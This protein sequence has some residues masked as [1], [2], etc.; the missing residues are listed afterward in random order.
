MR[1]LSALL[2]LVLVAAL[3]VVALSAQF[4]TYYPPSALFAASAI[5]SSS[6]DGVNHALFGVNQG[7][8][9]LY[10]IFLAPN[11]TPAFGAT[12][13]FPWVYGKLVGAQFI[14]AN[15]VRATWVISLSGGG[16]NAVFTPAATLT[17]DF[18]L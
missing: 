7:N 14:S 13:G 17:Q 15:V 4:P 5:T 8:G 2:A 11:G 9:D 6:L 18:V 3:P 10:L 16:V 12:G 1:K